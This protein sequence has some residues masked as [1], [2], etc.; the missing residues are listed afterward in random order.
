MTEEELL[1]RLIDA[2]ERI[3]TS[4]EKVTKELNDDD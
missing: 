4:L 1:K 3:A 2:L